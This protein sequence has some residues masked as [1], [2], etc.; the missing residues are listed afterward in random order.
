MLASGERGILCS[1]AHSAAHTRVKRNFLVRLSRCAM[2]GGQSARVERTRALAGH[3]RAWS[4]GGAKWRRTCPPKIGM[5]AAPGNMP[6]PHNSSS[7]SATALPLPRRLPVTVAPQG[8]PKYTRDAERADAAQD[9]QVR[10]RRGAWKRL[11]GAGIRRTCCHA[12][13]TTTGRTLPSETRRAPLWYARHTAPSP[14]HNE[15][16]H[17]S[18]RKRRTHSA[19]IK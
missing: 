5:C 16:R 11:T 14:V 3:R 13:S 15:L 17:I 1:Q 8:R 18:R 2:C 6:A 9:H 7:R 4:R 19:S 12:A 10:A